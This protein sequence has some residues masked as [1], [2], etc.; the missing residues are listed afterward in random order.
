MPHVGAIEGET[1]LSPGI[2]W[3]TQIL[4]E[5]QICDCDGTILA[6]LKLE[7]GESHVTANVDL[8]PAPA[9]APLDTPSTSHTT[10]L[11]RTRRTPL[12]LSTATVLIR[13]KQ[14][15]RPVRVGLD[16]PF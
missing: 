8:V 5:S 11:R 12:P 7:D 14:S 15:G 10:R 3:K 6:R 9:P 2:A 13:V 4:G 1:P 16:K